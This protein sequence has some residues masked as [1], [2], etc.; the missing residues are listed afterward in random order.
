MRFGIVRGASLSWHCLGNEVG[1]MTEDA[2]GGNPRSGLAVLCW[3][4]ELR[5]LGRNCGKRELRFDLPLV[6]PLRSP[7]GG[8]LPRGR[9]I[10]VTCRRGIVVGAFY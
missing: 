7:F 8:N 9:S 3:T 5:V 2:E 10:R 4:Y 1:R 6:G